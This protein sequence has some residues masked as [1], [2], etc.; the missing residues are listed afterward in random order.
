MLLVKT[1]LKLSK[2]H[3]IG[4]FAD[5]NIKKGQIV[6][7]KN[8]NCSYVIFSEKEWRELKR[9]TSPESFKQI[10]NYTYKYNR[11]GKYYCCLDDTRFMNHSSKP[12]IVENKLGN[13]IALRN[14][15]KGE[16]ILIDYETFFDP[17]DLNQE[18]KVWNK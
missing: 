11:D 13:D 5:E 1:K 15:K 4:L 16:E 10:R 14:I 12:N 3:G 18:R 17:E 8:K 9:K 7:K 6:W 2:I